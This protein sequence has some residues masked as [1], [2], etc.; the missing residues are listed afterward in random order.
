AQAANSPPR[1]SVVTVRRAPA[2]V[3][4]VLPGNS[5]AFREAALYA[6]TTGYLKRWL[7]DIGDRVQ[8]G[9]LIAEISAPDVD[10][11]LAQARANL[12]LAKTNLQV[13]EANLVLAKITLSRDLR[14]GVGTA[15]TTID[16]DQAQVQTSTAQVESAK[17]SIQANEATV[18][19]FTD[20]QSFQKIVAPFPGVITARS[21]D[22]GALITA[23]NP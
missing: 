9:Q 18:Q 5:Q 15:P 7:V 8:E 16:Q 6:R 3:Q 12:S 10:D 13:S 2:T 14:A 21:V 22:P 11:Q 17:A 1:V 23:E 4:H 19:Q 20:L